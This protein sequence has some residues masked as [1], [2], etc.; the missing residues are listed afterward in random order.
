[1][2]PCMISPNMT[3]KKNGNDINPKNEGL[4]SLYDGIPYVFVIN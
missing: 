1:M 4:T 2:A 3:P